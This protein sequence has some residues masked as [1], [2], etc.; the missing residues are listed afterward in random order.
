MVGCVQGKGRLAQ[1]LHH[2]ML[3]FGTP[4]H[5]STVRF[6][7]DKSQRVDTETLAYRGLFSGVPVPGHIG[8]GAGAGL[9][10]ACWPLAAPPVNR[11]GST[12]PAASTTR[13]TTPPS[14]LRFSRVSNVVIPTGSG[15][16]NSVNLANT[17]G[18]ITIPGADASLTVNGAFIDNSA[19]SGA[20]NKSGLR[21]SDGNATITATNTQ[22]KRVA[23]KHQ[24]DMGDRSAKLGPENGGKGCIM[25]VRDNRSA[26]HSDRDPGGK[27]RERSLPSLMQPGI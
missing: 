3:V 5:R 2:G 23:L 6:L 20:R 17:T 18:T 13:Q 10:S 21:I 27:R 16:V 14:A 26:G 4:W 25:T 9:R 19:V 1:C 15:V 8:T 12:I 22:I 7:P 24:W 11:A